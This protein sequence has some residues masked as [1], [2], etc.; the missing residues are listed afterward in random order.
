M[1]AYLAMLMARAQV[2][3]QYRVV[4]LAGVGTQVFWGLIK[5]MVFDAFYESTTAGQPMRLE[6]VVSYIWLSQA[7]FALLPWR[8]E[9]ELREL[10]R[11]GNVAYELTRPVDLYALWY[12]R[13]LA[14]KL[15]QPLMRFVPLVVVAGLF[16]NLQPPPSWQAGVAGFLSLIMAVLLASA[17]TMMLTI[18][19]LWTVAGDGMNRFVPPL[20]M[21]LSGNVIPLPFFPEWLQPLVRSLPFRSVIDVP[22]RLYTGDIPLAAVGY[23]IGFAFVWTLALVL[24]GRWILSIGVRRL[25]IQGG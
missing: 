22:V 24:M 5:I 7:L 4:A 8:V 13:T 23:E 25:V 9:P 18:T 16:L 15:I 10:M 17:I 3:A 6:D 1:R 2:I 14:T 20:T 19:L 21:L 12:S 11:S